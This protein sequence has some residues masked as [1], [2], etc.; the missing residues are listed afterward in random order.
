MDPLHNA[1]ATSSSTPVPPTVRRTKKNG[2][3]T[4]TESQAEVIEKLAREIESLKSNLNSQKSTSKSKGKKSTVKVT[5]PTANDVSTS[6]SS[7]SASKKK[8]PVPTT[9]N[10]NQRATSAPPKFMRPP[11]P[12]KSIS[13]TPVAKPSPKRH[14]QQIQTGDFPAAFGPT[15]ILWGLL[16]Q[17]SVPKPPELSKLEEFYRRFRRAE[18]VE[19]AVRSG[20]ANRDVGQVSCLKDAQGGRIKFGKSVIHLGSNFVRYAQGI[21]AQLG[22]SVWCPNLDE[23]S[24]SLYNAAHRIAALTTFTELAATPAY[25]YLKVDPAMAQ[26]MTLLIPAYNHFVHYLQAE[27][28]KK[29]IKQKGKVAQEASNK[30]HNKNRERLRDERRNFAILNKFPQRYRDILEPIAAHSD[31]EE[32][33]GKGFY[34]IKTLPYR[35]NNANRFFRRLD[36]VMKKAAEQDPLRKSSRRRVRRLPKEPQESLYKAAPKGLPIDFYHPKWFNELVPAQQHSIPDRTRIA[37]L[38]NANE[39]LLPKSEKNLDEKLKDSTFTRKYWEVVEESS[40]EEENAAEDQVNGQGD[41]GEG[42]D[43][44]QPSEG[45]DSDDE[46]HV[47]GDAGELY[48]EEGD[49][50]SFV[51]NDEQEDGGEDED[52]DDD[53]EYDEAQDGVGLDVDHPMADIPEGEEDW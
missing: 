3:P 1:W 29:E 35:S 22:L 41:E 30:K 2:S 53:E 26:N 20:S 12:R 24:G 31:D 38:P 10:R 42:I 45:S 17:D 5:N 37:F 14:P 16:R 25:A 49:D 19:E 11:K 18:Q 13:E 44:T 9:P 21:M 46:Y 4:D 23:D 36:V 6:S 47:E 48:D 50:E 43:L 39:S 15:K 28:Y 7:A 33:E 34:K 8:A 40:E 32:V 27:K 51:D 52:E